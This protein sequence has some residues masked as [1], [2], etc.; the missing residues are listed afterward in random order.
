MKEMEAMIMTTNTTLRSDEHK[1]ARIK[2]RELFTKASAC[3]LGGHTQTLG[4]QGQR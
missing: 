1:A 2:S 3:H 4:G